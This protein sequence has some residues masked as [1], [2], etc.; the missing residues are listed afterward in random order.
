MVVDYQALNANTVK[1]AYPLPL[2]QSLIEKL[3]GVKY[4]STLDLKSGYNLV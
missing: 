1:N 2:I 4:F 3:R